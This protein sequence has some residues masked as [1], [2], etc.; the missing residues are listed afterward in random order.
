MDENERMTH[1]SYGMLG[2]SR[3]SGNPGRL[4]GDPLPG[5][6][7]FI[8]MRLQ[9]GHFRPN[10]LGQDWHHATGE[11]VTVRL[12]GE[13]FARLLTSMNI[14]SGVPCTLHYI[15][16]VGPIEPPPLEKSEP[17]RVMD[18]SKARVRDL[19]NFVSRQSE[20]I[21][22]YLEAKKVPG[23]IRAKVR[24]VFSR[25]S[26]ELGPNL[27][28]AEKVIQEQYGRVVTTSIAE[29]NAAVTTLVEQTGLVELRRLGEGLKP[30][31]AMSLLDDDGEEG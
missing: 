23:A 9:R 6:S 21:G 30:G 7:T 20:E 2:F 13:Q 16:G 12:S 26:M 1:P 31:G 24:D 11:I 22:E 25:V 15:D 5:H 14:G 4:Y 17:H 19:A 28:F 8:E 10:H 27:Q 18:A 3:V 29:L